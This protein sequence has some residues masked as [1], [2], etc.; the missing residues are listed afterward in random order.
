[1][2]ESHEDA[3]GTMFQPRRRLG[4]FLM[5]V[6]VVFWIVSLHTLL[7]YVDKRDYTAA[8]RLSRDPS[9]MVTTP[10]R[11]PEV[12][13]GPSNTDPMFQ[14]GYLPSPSMYDWPYRWLSLP[15]TLIGVSLFFTGVLVGYHDDISE[16]F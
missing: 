3:F 11:L 8:P 9:A 1:M 14:G 5:V 4:I 6:S 13:N 15:L 7:F 16:L 10:N 12:Y 2:N